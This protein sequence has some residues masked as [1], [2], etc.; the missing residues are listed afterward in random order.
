MT[1]LVTGGAGYVGSH[2]VKELQAT[3][4]PCVVMDN[5][6]RGHRDLIPGVELVVGDI[7]DAALV[8]RVI[9]DYRVDAVMHFA[10]CSDVG[11]SNRMPL[12]Y[13]A[14]NVTTTINLVTAMVETDVKRLVFSSTCAT[15]GIPDVTPI[16]EDHPQRPIN[17]YG[18]TKLMVERILQDA[19]RAHGLRFVIFR[20]FNAA[21]AHP[22]GA[23]GER[24]VPETHLIPLALHVVAGLRDRLDIYGSDYPTPDGTCIRDYIHVV[25]LARAHLLGLHYLES[26]QPSEAFNLGNGSGFSVM[27]IIQAVER[28]TGRGVR[29]VT[30]PRRPGDPPILVGSSDKARRL[31]GW[32]P[33]FPTVDAIIETA[34]R[35]HRS[36]PGQAR[37]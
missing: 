16:V 20:Y 22:S 23:I 21:G 18:A 37:A 7:G 29:T 13:Y 32:H 3:G 33:E 31:L 28:V 24:H 6:V 5:L 36:G 35:W 4:I 11:E 10:A 30:G 19:D 8:R 1:I 25:D 14:G 34:W 12:K 27:E 15:Y 26:G 17:P 9:R 2:L